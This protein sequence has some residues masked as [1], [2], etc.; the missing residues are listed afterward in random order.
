[1][2]EVRLG[3][4]EVEKGRL[5]KLCMVCGTES[6]LKVK[7]TF[8]WYPRWIVALIIF[9]A[10][11]AFIVAM[12]LTKKM[13]IKAP[14]CHDHRNHWFGRSLFLYLGL[15]VM[16]LIG[17]LLVM[18]VA[19]QSGQHGRDNNWMG[20]ACLGSVV[21]FLVWLIVAA[22]LQSTG[23]Q[24]TEITDKSITLKGVDSTFLSELQEHRQSRKREDQQEKRTP[25]RPAPL[26]EEEESDDDD[27][28]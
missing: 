26:L 23:I 25:R 13:T 19:I 21:L 17:F 12:I 4:F 5:P 28:D 20:F 7:K 27:D 18:T 10:L 2:A 15:L 11:P 6:S 9:G 1:M 24:A 14:L 22:I 16:G 8:S 3:K